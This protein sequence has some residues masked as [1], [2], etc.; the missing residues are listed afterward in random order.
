MRSL[1]LILSTLFSVTA[2]AYAPPYTLILSRVAENHGHGAFVIDQDVTFHSDTDL[3]IHETWTIFDENHMKLVFQGVGPLKDSVK[4]TFVYDGSNR[5]SNDAGA[6]AK[7][8]HVGED[9]AESLFAFRFSKAMR[10]HLVAMKIAPPESVKEPAPLKSDGPPDYAPEWFVK[11]VRDNGKVSWAI[12]KAAGDDPP[13]L[14]IEQDQFVVSRIRFPSK[15]VI[16][17]DDYGKFDNG[18]YFPRKRTYKFGGKTVVVNVHSVKA[19]GN[20]KMKDTAVVPF[21]IAA[22]DVFK[23]FYLRFR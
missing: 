17:A 20:I 5:V 3:T 10:N 16:D 6:G 14:C 9:W 4:G 2:L 18:L 19:L 7:S 21:Q 12:T 15:S 11:L 23:E 22:G 8:H 13:E 1:L